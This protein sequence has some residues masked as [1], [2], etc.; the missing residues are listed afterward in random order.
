MD[1][2][3]FNLQPP[4]DTDGVTKILELTADDLKVPA[5]VRTVADVE[6]LKSYLERWAK[7]DRTVVYCHGGSIVAVIDEEENDDKVV[8]KMERTRQSVLWLPLLQNKKVSLDH[9]SFKEFLED[10]YAEVEDGSSLFANV[11]TL[12]LATT[13]TYDAKLQ[14]DRSYSIAIESNDSASV[15]KLPKFVN[16][17]IPIWEGLQDP[18]AAPGSD[19]VYTFPAKLLFSAPSEDRKVPFFG[20]YCETVRDVLDRS[21]RD[22]TA[23]VRTALKDW[24][25][26]NGVPGSTRA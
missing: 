23:Q 25:V 16:V 18:D 1:N 13:F 10:R 9:K 3:R 4:A 7:P 21:E 26:L 14:N 8:L 17:E 24:Q 22:I 2:K 19:K 20:L 5:R 15:T 12:S 6:S 11:S